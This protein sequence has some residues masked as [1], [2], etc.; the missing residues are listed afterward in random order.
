MET[1]TC[2]LL[3][4]QEN[5]WVHEWLTPHYHTTTGRKRTVSVWTFNSISDDELFTCLW[6]GMHENIVISGGVGPV[7]TRQTWRGDLL[8]PSVLHTT[9][10]H[11][12]WQQQQQH[13]HLCTEENI[14]KEQPIMSVIQCN[15]DPSFTGKHHN[16]NNNEQ[17][18]MCG[19]PYLVGLLLQHCSPQWPRS[20]KQCAKRRTFCRA[21]GPNSPTSRFAA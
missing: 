7:Q 4:E 1:Q 10:S 19:R 2:A 18:V 12:V 5:Q 6:V 20:G 9:G 17:P 8:C 16:N 14:L 15:P 11:T 21:A 3:A 13:K